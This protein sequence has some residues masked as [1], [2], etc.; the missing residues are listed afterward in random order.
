M[1]LGS[2][3]HTH[4]FMYQPWTILFYYT[5]KDRFLMRNNIFVSPIITNNKEANEPRIYLF[6]KILLVIVSSIK[7]SNIFKRSSTVEKYKIHWKLG[8]QYTSQ[9]V[10]LE[11]ALL[12]KGWYLVIVLNIFENRKHQSHKFARFGIPWLELD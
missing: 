9:E 6:F 1:I 4:L 7:K 8:V 12:N 2:L 3:Y 10:I 5:K 11:N